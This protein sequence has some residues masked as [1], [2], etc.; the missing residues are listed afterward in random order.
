MIAAKIEG[1]EVAKVPDTPKKAEVV[2]ILQ[3]LENSLKLVRKPMG[4]TAEA[5]PQRKSKRG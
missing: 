5:G 1:S 2:D 3:A 4:Q